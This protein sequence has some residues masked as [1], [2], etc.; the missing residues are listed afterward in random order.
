MG[1]HSNWTG[2]CIVDRDVMPMINLAIYHRNKKHSYLGG[3]GGGGGGSHLLPW[4]QS[5]NSITCFWHKKV[6]IRQ[7][8]RH[9]LDKS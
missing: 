3:G 6:G 8:K 4:S 9:P 1:C 5:G 7:L 2:E